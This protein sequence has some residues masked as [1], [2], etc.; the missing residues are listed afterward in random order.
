MLENRVK[1]FFAAEPKITTE[2][3]ATI[4]RDVA[5]G[6]GFGEYARIR[7][8]RLRVVKEISQSLIFNSYL[9]DIQIPSVFHDNGFVVNALGHRIEHVAYLGIVRNRIGIV[10]SDRYLQALV[11]PEDPIGPDIDLRLE[12]IQEVTAHECYHIRQFNR[13]PGRATNDAKAFDSVE[14]LDWD[15]TRIEVAAQRYAQLY[16]TERTRLQRERN[17]IAFLRDMGIDP[18]GIID[19]V[20]QVAAVASETIKK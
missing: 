17:T 4:G 13:F 5:F 1:N 8:D 6:I 2:G 20:G 18:T 10:Y 9:L 15:K 14:A 16:E 3:L 11:N 19:K 7:G 12:P